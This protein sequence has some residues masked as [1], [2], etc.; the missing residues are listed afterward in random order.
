VTREFETNTLVER[1]LE[2]KR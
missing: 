1:L 2:A